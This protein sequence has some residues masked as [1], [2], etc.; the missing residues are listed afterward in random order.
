MR[1]V[2]ELH[3]LAIADGDG[4]DVLANGYDGG[5]AVPDSLRIH[6]YLQI[7]Y[8]RQWMIVGLL[9][10]GALA[11]AAYNWRATPLY[12]GRA[13]LLIDGDTNVLGL[14]RPVVDQR[15]WLARLPT[16]AARHPAEPLSCPPSQ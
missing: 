16:H 3:R 6:D 5:M 10:L 9:L 4:D 7:L 12:A 2:S 15:L 8:R 13:R 11:A 1:R 14:D